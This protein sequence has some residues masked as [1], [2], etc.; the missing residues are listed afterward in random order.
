MTLY[1]LERFT[2]EDLSHFARYFIGKRNRYRAI[3]LGELDERPRSC[4]R[5]EEREINDEDLKWIE[6]RPIDELLVEHAKRSWTD[7]DR[8]KAQDEWFV[9]RDVQ[10]LGQEELVKVQKRLALYKA[11]RHDEQDAQNAAVAKA[12]ARLRKKHAKMRAQMKKERDAVIA[13]AIAPFAKKR[14]ER[15]KARQRDIRQMEALYKKIQAAHEAEFRASEYIIRTH[16]P[17]PYDFDKTVYVAGF[18]GGRTKLIKSQKKSLGT[19][20]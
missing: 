19:I 11:P 16:G 12:A 4:V 9:A 5:I 8:E 18:S 1:F 13:K 10:R 20:F 17:G 6:R 15:E 3:C 2:R 7:R 14:A